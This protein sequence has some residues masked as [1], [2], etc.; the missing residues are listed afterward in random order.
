MWKS[1]LFIPYVKVKNQRSK[2]NSKIRKISHVFEHLKPITSFLAKLTGT[3]SSGSHLNGLSGYTRPDGR[4]CR[5]IFFLPEPGRFLEKWPVTDS[6]LKWLKYFHACHENTICQFGTVDAL[7]TRAKLKL[8]KN[9]KINSFHF[10]LD[11]N[12]QAV[13][14][15]RTV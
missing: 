13:Q 10:T 11:R 12:L 7:I 1:C 3:F 2:I 15:A 14:V 4:V 5:L 8:F 9:P 6:L